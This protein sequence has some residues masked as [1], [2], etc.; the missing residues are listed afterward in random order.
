MRHTPFI[1]LLIIAFASCV[2]AAQPRGGLPQGGPRPAL[3]MLRDHLSLP[4]ESRPD[5]ATQ[6]FA[7]LPLTYQQS[8][9]AVD[10][11]WNDALQRIRAER[12]AEWQAKAITIDGRTMKF[13]FRTFGEPDTDPAGGEAGGRP[14][15]ISMHGG[16]NAPPEVNEKQWQNQVRLYQPAEG[17]YLAPRAPTDTWNLWHE[18]HIDAF[19]D[20][21][22]ADAVAFEN[23]DPERVYLMGYSAGGDGVYQVASRMAD[24]LAA[25]AMMA[26]HPN[27]AQPVNLRNLPFAIHMGANDSAYDRNTVAAS[28]GAKLDELHAADAEG[29]IHLTKLHEGKGHWMDRED[30]EALPWM[31]QHTREAWPTRVVWRQDDVTHKRLYWLSVP[32][33]TRTP[34]STIIARFE[35][36]GDEQTITIEVISGFGDLDSIEVTILLSDDLL[37]LDRPI[38]VRRGD[39][40]LYQGLVMRTIR[41]MAEALEARTDRALLPTASLT[42]TVPLEPQSMRSPE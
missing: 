9:M 40:V 27:E 39:A 28:W 26:G 16:G 23:V 22:I 5:L 19:F 20:R 36:L 33:T 15:F 11:L 17:V 32:D 10:A 25:A 14:L 30:A 13:D 41:P 24:R 42:V 12:A 8:Q 3:E 7:D 34:G 38:I 29:Y 6:T 18:A 31:M 37:N 4:I 21:I 2:A 1:A 35:N